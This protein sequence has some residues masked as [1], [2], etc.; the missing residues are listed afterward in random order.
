MADWYKRGVDEALHS[1][2]S[3]A[4]RG[5]TTQQHVIGDLDEPH[6]GLLFVVPVLEAY[7]LGRKPAV[8]D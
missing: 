8:K 5:L 2:Q 6:T 1:L 4:N 7:G 3:D